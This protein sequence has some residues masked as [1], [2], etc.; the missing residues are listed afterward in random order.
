[1]RFLRAT[2]SLAVVYVSAK[3]ACSLLSQKVLSTGLIREMVDGFEALLETIRTETTRCF[4]WHRTKRKLGAPAVSFGIASHRRVTTLAV[5]LHGAI[6]AYNAASG[7][8][9]RLA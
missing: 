6:I 9:F 5:R 1:M 8:V 2:D 4:C 7:Y 3:S